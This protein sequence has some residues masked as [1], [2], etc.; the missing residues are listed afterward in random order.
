LSAQ[1]ESRL[2]PAFADCEYAIPL[3]RVMLMLM[4]AVQA[5]SLVMGFA[6]DG[7]KTDDPAAEYTTS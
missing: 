1:D 4:L 5:E 3:L 7:L 6:G 2:S